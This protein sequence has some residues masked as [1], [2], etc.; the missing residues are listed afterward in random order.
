MGNFDNDHEN[1]SGV[2]NSF[3][4]FIMQKILVLQIVKEWQQNIL[5]VKVNRLLK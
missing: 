5:I 4:S 2:M 3:N 1:V